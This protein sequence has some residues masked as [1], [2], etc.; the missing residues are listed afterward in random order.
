MRF[1][2]R[3][4]SH[5]RRAQKGERVRVGQPFGRKVKQ[6]EPPPLES[7]ANRAVGRGVEIGV[8]RRRRD[9][10]SFQ[11]LRLVAHQGDQGGDDD[12]QAGAREGWKLVNQ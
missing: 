3:Q 9:P 10:Q 1:V 2:H 5:L 12:G 8:Q 6:A 4:Q 11:F 7:V